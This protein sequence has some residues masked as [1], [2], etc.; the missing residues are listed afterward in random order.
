MVTSAHFSKEN[1]VL[2]NKSQTPFF[3]GLPS[4]ENLL[5]KNFGSHIRQPTIWTDASYLMF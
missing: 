3:F 4:G 1:K 2:L 5:E